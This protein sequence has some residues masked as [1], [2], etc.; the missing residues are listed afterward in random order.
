MSSWIQQHPP[1]PNPGHYSDILKKRANKNVEH[2]YQTNK[3]I[4]L[5]IMARHAWDVD[6]NDRSPVSGI[7]SAG[8]FCTG[9][10]R[11]STNLVTTSKF[12]VLAKGDMRQVTYWAPR[13]TRQCTQLLT[14]VIWHLGFVDLCFS[15]MQKT[16]TCMLKI[17]W[18]VGACITLN[19]LSTR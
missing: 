5:A 4:C 13:N 6:G 12:Q 2:Q 11:F 19:F 14:Q 17:L 18:S 10:Y 1:L 15:T 3:L 9:M 8:S 16:K 7:A